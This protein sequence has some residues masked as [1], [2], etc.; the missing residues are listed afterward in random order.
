MIGFVPAY[1]SVAESASRQVADPVVAIMPAARLC[2][3]LGMTAHA[4][5]VE[6]AVASDLL[7]RQGQRAAC[8]AAAVYD[9]AERVSG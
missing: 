4:A 8:G 3:H 1:A 9:R 7:D 2:D 5:C 6:H